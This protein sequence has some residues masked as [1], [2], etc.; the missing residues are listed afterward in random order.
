MS[1]AAAGAAACWALATLAEHLQQ[2][3]PSGMALLSQ[4]RSAANFVR[5]TVAHWGAAVPAAV[6]EQP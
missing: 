6:Q 4:M 2:A 3:A 1:N 5:C